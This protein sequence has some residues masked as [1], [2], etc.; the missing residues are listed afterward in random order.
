[1]A[2]SAKLDAAG[3]QLL[4][5]GSASGR[6]VALFIQ[7]VEPFDEGELDALR[8]DG[9]ELRSVIDDIVTADVDADAIGA[10]SDHEFVRAISLSGPLYPESGAEPDQS[11]FPGPS[12]DVI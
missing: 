1:M 3:R 5:D 6:R 11:G 2:H 10:L 7:G 12:A 8:A 9:A 4:A